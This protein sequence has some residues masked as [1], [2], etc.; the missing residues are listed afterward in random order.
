VF[1]P[2]RDQI[3]PATREEKNRITM[4]GF[5]PLTSIVG[6]KQP[7]TELVEA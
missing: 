1:V 5:V 6:M 3:R 4:N 7:A 2:E